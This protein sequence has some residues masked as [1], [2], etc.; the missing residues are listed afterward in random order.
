MVGALVVSACA[1][2]GT[3][4]AG[5]PDVPVP[6][7]LA[8]DVGLD[9]G[10]SF[11]RLTYDLE[12]DLALAAYA[13]TLEAAGFRAVGV[14]RGWTHFTDGRLVI[15]ARTEPGPPTLVLVRVIEGGGNG[16]SPYP[17]GT[18]DPSATPVVAPPSALPSVQPGQPTAPPGKTQA[19]PVRRPD[20]PHRASSGNA[21]GNGNGN[22]GGN[23]NGNSGGNGNGNSGGKPDATPRNSG[24]K[25]DATPRPTKSP[26]P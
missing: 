22:S 6:P 23:G 7:G 5:T 19:A 13:G 26:K 12:P 9:E 17:V 4:P 1:G 11:Y 3:Q 25:P 20:P 16:Q 10:G 24:G 2:G 21:G 14:R 15:A 8:V 18:G